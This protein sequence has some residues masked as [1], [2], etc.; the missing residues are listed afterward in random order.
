VA[1]II[2]KIPNNSFR[3]KSLV[4]S[5]NE[6]EEVDLRF[7]LIRRGLEKKLHLLEIQSTCCESWYYDLLWNQRC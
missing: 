2:S 3:I 5:D 7:P 6:F 1:P 4:K